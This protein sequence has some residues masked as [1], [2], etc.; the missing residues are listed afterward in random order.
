[1]EIKKIVGVVTSVGDGVFGG[2]ST[3]GVTTYSYMELADGT[4]FTTLRVRTGVSSQLESAIT[5]GETAE[6]HV[7][8]MKKYSILVA[9]RVGDGRLFGTRIAGPGFGDYCVL[10]VLVA[11][12]VPMTAF[13]GAGLV[14]LWIAWK[15]WGEMSEKRTLRAYVDGLSGA[16][17][18]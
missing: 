12:G 15:V 3:A 18:V 6:L 13:L 17:V 4:V 1:M 14:A 10:A 7:A 8:Q 16:V 2:G 11:F 5:S 9:I